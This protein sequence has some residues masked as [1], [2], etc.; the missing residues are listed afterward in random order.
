[1]KNIPKII[2][3]NIDTDIEEVKDF[4]ELSEVS[5]CTDKINSTD[6]K[7]IHV[8]ELESIL[9]AHKEAIKE[10]V[11]Y[12]HTCNNGKGC[13]IPYCDQLCGNI[14][15]EPIDT[16]SKNFIDNLKQ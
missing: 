14:D 13:G 4:K 10:G 8:S 7:Y 3:L 2:Y 1:M 16:A 6:L 15:K 9:E 11:K 5:W 12:Q